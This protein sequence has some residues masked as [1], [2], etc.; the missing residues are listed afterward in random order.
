AIN[1]GN[2]G[3]PLLDSAG[4]LIGIN[5]LIYSPSG[6]YA[7][8]GFAVPVDTVNRIVPKLISKGRYERPNPGIGMDEELN[9]AIMQQLGLKGVAVLSVYPNSGAAAAGLRPAQRD[10]RGD[11]LIG[12]IIVAVDGKTTASPSAMISLLDEHEIGDRVQLTLLRE[13]KKVNVMVELQ[14]AQR[15]LRR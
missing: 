9:Q 12:D 15:G 14:G 11:L 13:N 6:A 1:P 3:G 10:R 4:R 2:S 8:V 7:G 5:T